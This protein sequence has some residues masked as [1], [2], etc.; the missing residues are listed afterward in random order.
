M[1]RAP[2]RRRKRTKFAAMMSLKIP[3]KMP[4]IIV[5]IDETGDLMQTAPAD[6]ESAIARITQMGGAAGIHIIVAT[7][8]TRGCYHGRNSRRTF[9]AGSRFSREQDR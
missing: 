5:I 6:V 2:R 3:D 1:W 9:R 7:N 4:Y 8:T